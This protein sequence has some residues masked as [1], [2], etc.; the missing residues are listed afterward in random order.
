MSLVSRSNIL[1][2]HPDP[3]YSDS[4]GKPMAESTLQYRWIVTIKEGIERL[5]ADRDDVFVAADLLWYPIEGHPEIN[6]APDAMVVFGRPRNPH[7]RS[8]RQWLEEDLAPQVVF[9]VLSHTNTPADSEAKRRFYQVHGVDEYYVYDPQHGT[10]EGYLRREQRLD[11]I[12]AILGW[13]SPRLGVRF[14]R[15]GKDLLLTGPDGRRFRSFQEWVRSSARFREQYER[16]R[17]R[18]EQER[19]RAERERLRAVQAQEQ[20][21][22]AREH[23]EQERLRAE[24][25]QERLEQER[26]ETE[27]AQQEAE[28]ERLRA[29]E[30]DR[31]L[32]DLMRRLR[33]SGLDPDEV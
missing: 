9:E 16:Y 11:P 28:R 5:L 17:D 2:P 10:L 26:Q 27:R 32:T 20:A 25:A 30:A 1:Y 29:E 7:R 19:Q 21:E 33:E 24:Q 23:A 13:V 15:R 31:R 18:A 14:E 4:D 8:Y 22:Q 3:L 12:E 6:A